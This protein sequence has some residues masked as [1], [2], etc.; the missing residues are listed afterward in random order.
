MIKVYIYIV[1]VCLCGGGL[2]CFLH[3][4]FVYSKYCSAFVFVYREFVYIQNTQFE[5]M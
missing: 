1:C 2:L 5:F 3:Y 4:T